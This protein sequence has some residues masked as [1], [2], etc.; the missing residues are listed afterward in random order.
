MF[1]QL[2][3]GKEEEEEAGAKQP[4]VSTAEGS[5]VVSAI[6]FIDTGHFYGAGPR[7]T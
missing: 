3:L 5:H 1:L 6:G 7:P 2:R 4:M